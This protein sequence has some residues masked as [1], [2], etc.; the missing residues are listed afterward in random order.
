MKKTKIRI[1]ED[2]LYPYGDHEPKPCKLHPEGKHLWQFVGSAHNPQEFIPKYMC[3]RATTKGL[4][5]NEWVWVHPHTLERILH[6][7]HTNG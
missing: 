3:V 7:L 2:T 1:I 6:S 5:C 4:S